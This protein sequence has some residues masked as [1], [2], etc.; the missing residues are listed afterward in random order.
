MNNKTNFGLYFKNLR[1]SQRL[2][3]TA[4][5]NKSEVSPSY[6]SRIEK[7]NRNAPQPEI[8]GKLAPHLN[9][10]YL[11]LM[12]KAGHIPK[13]SDVLL[14]DDDQTKHIILNM[15]ESKKI[16]FKELDYLDEETIN[17]FIDLIKN[18]KRNFNIKGSN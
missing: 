18:F 9:I 4:L 5:A 16:L 6:L 8:L 13:D 14:V 1:E 2:T 15:S 10:G 7:G 17:S 12:L 11:E 3:I